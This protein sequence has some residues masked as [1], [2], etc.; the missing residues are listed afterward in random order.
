MKV[1]NFRG[2]GLGVDAQIFRVF[3]TSVIPTN[4][5]GNTD[6]TRQQ[7]LTGINITVPDAATEGF[8]VP[9]TAGCSEQHRFDFVVNTPAPVNPPP[10]PPPPPPSPAPVEPPPTPVNT[11]PL[12][13][14]PPQD[15]IPGEAN[16][17]I[18]WTL[19]ETG[20]GNGGTLS[21]TTQ[22]DTGAD[23]NGY[24]F[25]DPIYTAP[26][27]FTAGS[28]TF[29][30]D[31][32]SGTVTTNSSISRICTV[33]LTANAVTCEQYRI[34]NYGVGDVVI[35]GYTECG[36]GAE[37]I[38]NIGEF[39]EMVVCSRTVPVDTQG[40][41]FHSNPNA[42][43]GNPGYNPQ[44]RFILGTSCTQNVPT[45]P[46]PPPPSGTLSNSEQ[47]ISLDDITPSVHRFYITT[48]GRW[49]IVAD[50]PDGERGI[51]FPSSGNSGTTA[52]TNKAINLRYDGG[53]Y[54]DDV[55][56]DWFLKVEGSVVDTFT[57]YYGVE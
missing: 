54:G 34:R 31:S 48:S 51:D 24:S 46:P 17:T 1:I 40:G 37:T 32:L 9:T 11:E 52:V 5:V 29:T 4:R 42:G 27:G 35:W 57:V 45:P 10:P 39:S 22:T 47:E 6:F 49:E 33:V 28:V 26:E 53:G 50:I 3:H 41:P 56:Y 55:S 14:P 23:P 30:G 21:Y 12:P 15:P 16:I 8:L 38:V 13:T 36:S 7:I 18:T 43:V 20:G 2:I 44:Q 25:T 19:V